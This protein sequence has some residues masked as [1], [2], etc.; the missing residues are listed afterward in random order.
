MR[1]KE[2]TTIPRPP[3][4]CVKARQKS[5]LFGKTS[6]SLMQVAPVVVKP[7]IVSKKALATSMSVWQRYGTMPTIEKIIQERETMRKLSARRIRFCS[8]LRLMKT[9]NAPTAIAPSAVSRKL[10]H[11]SS[12]LRSATTIESNRKKPSM[13]MSMPRIPFFTFSTFYLFHFLSKACL[14]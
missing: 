14:A 12:P 3:I 5:K 1:A 8:P 6:I 10:T 7:L 13:M 11:A 2:K 9:H 4:H